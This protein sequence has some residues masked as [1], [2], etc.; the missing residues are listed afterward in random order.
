MSWNRPSEK[1]EK[2]ERGGRGNVHLRGLA[3]GGIVVL[4]AALAAWWLWPEGEEAAAVEREERSLIRE[5]QPAKASVRTNQ[6]ARP[7][8]KELPKQRVGEVRDGYRLLPNGR[9]HKVYGAV[10]CEVARISLEDKIFDEPADR[11]IAGVLKTRPGETYIGESTDYFREFPELF[12]RAIKKPI[13]INPDD[14]EEVREMKQAVIDA[15]LELKQR[16]DAGED[17][18][19]VMQDTR[20][21]LREL[22][23]YRE[24]IERQVREIAETKEDLDGR[25]AKDLLDAANKMLKDRGIEPLRVPAA[26]AYKIRQYKYEQKTQKQSNEG[27]ET[28]NE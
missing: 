11:D 4:G 24:E 27:K 9:L 25:D 13:V 28:E 14:S 17:L 12:K 15:R 20:E 10:T 1:V 23:L 26:L 3:A 5:V 22:G 21:Q 2:K 16:M 6:T 8:P 18:T 7:Q 19:K